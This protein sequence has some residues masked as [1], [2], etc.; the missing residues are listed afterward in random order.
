MSID[1]IKRY[2]QIVNE[3]V[4]TSKPEKTELDEAEI[5]VT[6]TINKDFENK[7]SFLRAMKYMESANGGAYTEICIKNGGGKKESAI[8]GDGSDRVTVEITGIDASYYEE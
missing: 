2:R 6:I 3:D 7:K 4:D 1:D 8:D 5:T